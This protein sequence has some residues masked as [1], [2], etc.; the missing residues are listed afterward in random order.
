MIVL[1]NEYKYKGWEVEEGICL[2]MNTYEWS[3]C[4]KTCECCKTC[5]GSIVRVG[6]QSV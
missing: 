6:G 2:R 5:G 3:C 1:R 4:T